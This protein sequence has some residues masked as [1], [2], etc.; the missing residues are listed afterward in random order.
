MSKKMVSLPLKKGLRQVPPLL[1]KKEKIMPT[2]AK[3]SL[4]TSNAS[5]VFLSIFFYKMPLIDL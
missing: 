1:P 3:L 2:A 5:E 4:V